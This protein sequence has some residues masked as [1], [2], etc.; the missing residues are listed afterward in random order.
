MNSSRFLWRKNLNS[1]LGV[2]YHLNINDGI[3]LEKYSSIEF[4]YI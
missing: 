2:L 3:S 4:M 1:L